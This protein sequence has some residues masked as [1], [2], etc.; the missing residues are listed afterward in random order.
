MVQTARD[1][2]ASLQSP[3]LGSCPDRTGDDAHLPGRAACVRFGR[4]LQGIGSVLL[5]PG[6][7]AMVLGG[8]AGGERGPAG[9]GAGAGRGTQRYSGPV[10]GPMSAAN[11]PR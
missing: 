5:A 11:R 3:A 9:R 1:R 4:I 10:T 7:R 8:C 2:R 6:S